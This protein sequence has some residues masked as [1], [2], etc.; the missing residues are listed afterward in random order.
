MQSSHVCKKESEKNYEK[1]KTNK[2]ISFFAVVQSCIQLK[3][4]FQVYVHQT[5]RLRR[6][7][8]DML[9]IFRPANHSSTATIRNNQ[10]ENRLGATGVHSEIPGG[11]EWL[12]VLFEDGVPG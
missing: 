4:A 9:H 3:N 7:S 1:N 6:D 2:R 12:Y 5:H 8:L 11:Y 10:T